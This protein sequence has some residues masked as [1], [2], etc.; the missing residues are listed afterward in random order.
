[1]LLLQGKN[2]NETCYEAGFASLSYFIRAFKKLTGD[3]PA[4]FKRKRS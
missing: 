2:V 3:T 1:L 4:V